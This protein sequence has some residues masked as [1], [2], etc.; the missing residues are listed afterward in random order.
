MATVS[1]F[2][3]SHSSFPSCTD[4]KTPTCA[5]G[6]VA[7]NCRKGGWSPAWTTLG[8]ARCVQELP[9]EA[10]SPPAPGVRQPGQGPEPTESLSICP[11]LGRRG[12]GLFLSV[13]THGDCCSKPTSIQTAFSS[14]AQLRLQEPG[15]CGH[16][17][18]GDGAGL[19]HDVTCWCPAPATSSQWWR[20]EG[21]ISKPL[22]A[23]SW[24]GA[25]LLRGHPGSATI[26]CFT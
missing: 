23:V 5:T 1:G 19:P 18:P 4:R 13:L 25:F 20:V 8:G 24:G 22:V 3:H 26:C 10:L 11:G 6:S 16:H 9:A 15:L 12:S 17:G 7:G 14:P 21:L 2:P